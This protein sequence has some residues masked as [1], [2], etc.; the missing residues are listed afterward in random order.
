M[1]AS[2]K[3]MVRFAEAIVEVCVLAVLY[4][5]FWRN[6]YEEGLFPSYQ[7]NGKYVLTGVY[8]ILSWLLIKNSDGF[9]F[10]NLRKFDLGIAQWFALLLVDGI[11]YFQLCLIGNKMVSP[12]PMAALYIVDGF[13]SVSFVF[14]YDHL[15]RVLY[16]A[17]HMLMI[18]GRDE[19]VGLKLKLDTCKERYDVYKMLPADESWKTI[20]AEIDRAE[21]V[22]VSDVPA[23][24]RNDILKYCYEN[25]IRFYTTPK[26]TDILIRGASSIEAIDTPLLLVKGGGLTIGQRFFKRTMDIVLSL[27]AMIPAAPI[28]LITALAIHLDDHG[29]VFY[30][31]R[32]VTIGG[33][34]FDIL[35]FRSMI[36]GAEKAGH[37]IPATSRDPRITRVGRFI[38]PTRIDELPQL[39]NILKGDMS[40]VG[41]RPERIEHVQKYSA[42]ISEFVY[43]QKVKGGLTGYAQIYGKYNTSAYDKLRLDLMYIENYSLLLDIKLMLLTVRV[44]FSRSSTEGFEK[45]RS[46]EEKEQKL[47]ESLRGEKAEELER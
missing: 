40:V 11:T 26:I 30:R 5:F 23:Q 15:Y 35:K 22:V 32:R 16:T 44:L 2:T 4:Y 9:K 47:L 27:V 25:Q 45:V 18:Y 37:S 42:E 3:T 46:N 41:P 13:V 14:F 12:L 36:V 10:G 34:E 17:H 7:G 29:P 43:R 1:D 21:S 8:A 19:A 24:K 38:R 39:F 20:C 28:M 33:K 6:G 31:Q